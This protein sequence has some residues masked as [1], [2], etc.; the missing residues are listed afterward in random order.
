MNTCRIMFYKGAKELDEY[1]HYPD[2]H[3]VYKFNPFY[4]YNIAGKGKVQYSW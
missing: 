3:T 1:L 2:S 4:P